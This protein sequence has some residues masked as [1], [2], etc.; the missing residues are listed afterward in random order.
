MKC[1]TDYKEWQALLHH[2]DDIAPLHMRDWMRE[3]NERFSRFTL[4]TEALFLDYSRNRITDKTINLLCD[5]AHAM[6]LP[7]KIKAFFSGDAINI[8]ENRPVLHTALRDHHHAPIN[9]HGENIALAIRAAEDKLEDFVSKIHLGTW[10]GVT[11]KSIKH[12]V[13]IGIGGSY[14]GPMMAIEALKDFAATNLQCHFIATVDP[15]HLQAILQTIDPESTLFIISSKSF[16][17]TETLSNAKCVLNWLQ[18][19]L[20]TTVLSQHFI[21]VTA[22]KEKALAFGIPAENIFPLWDWVGGRYSIWSAIGLPLRLMIGNEHFADFL[23]GA[24]DIDQHFQ[25]AEFNKNMPVIL[26]LLSI[27]Y[28][29]F[30]AAKAQAIIPYA[31]RLR[32]LIAYLQQAE[33]ESNGKSIALNGELISYATGAVLFGEEG[34][35]GQHAYH[36]L[37]HQGKQLI[38]VDILLVG[39]SSQENAFDHQQDLLLASGISQAQALMQGKTYLEAKEELITHHHSEETI[40]LLAKHQVIPGNRPSNIIFINQLTPYSLGALIALYE[41]KI[42]VEGALWNINSFDQ[43][44]VELGKKLLPEILHCMQEKTYH[45]IL[46]TATMT[47]IN[48]IKK[49][50]NNS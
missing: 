2:Y 43:W 45:H 12:I 13:N 39:K 20:G 50:R 5:L 34:C 17:T 27:W 35:I 49:S 7:K 40:A 18:D 14:T 46:D 26:A 22:R 23:K 29:N 6:E 30:F 42:F 19:K 32:Y 9:V 48:H 3:D 36:Q 41:H 8:T 10:K 31:Y 38:P 25:Q 1:I 24:Y 47:L 16:S 4:Q 44:G 21:A 33:M 11:G 15:L 28:I 37:L